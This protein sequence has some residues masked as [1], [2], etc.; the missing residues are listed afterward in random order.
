MTIEILFPDVLG[1]VTNGKR[2]VTEDIQYAVGIFPTQAFYN[3]PFEVVVLLQNTVMQDKQVQVSLVVPSR[4]KKGNP[5]RIL[6][7]AMDVKVTVPAGDVGLLRIPLAAE[8]PTPPGGPYPIRVDVTSRPSGLRLLPISA[9]GEMVRP[10]SGGPP[11]SVLA[12]SPFRMQVMQEIQFIDP[13]STTDKP[14]VSFDLVNKRMPAQVVPAHSYETVW[15]ASQ[16]ADERK[17]AAAQIEEARR[18]VFSISYGTSYYSFLEVTQERF[19]IAGMPLHPGEAKAISK[20]MA[21]TVDE[22]PSLETAIDIELLPWFRAFCQLIAADPTVTD[23]ERGTIY[24]RHLYDSILLDTIRFSFRIV[25]PKV[26]ENLGDAREQESYA[27]KLL[28]WLSG[29]GV[30]DLNYIYLPLV[31]GGVIVNRLV[32][33]DRK[34]NPWIMIQELQE[35]YRGRIALAGSS[36]TVIVFEILADLLADAE[37]NLRDARVPRP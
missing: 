32:M 29:N 26:R 36:A 22:S 12:V 10:P 16:A 34:D 5:I 8:P 15:S 17:L 1:A 18:I 6:A 4:D 25:Q 21:Y 20:I 11:P 31:M 23:L 33:L 37:R 27:N 9:R 14:K 19:A 3:Q 13:S 7:D 28:S 2:F 24:A 30:I 35:A